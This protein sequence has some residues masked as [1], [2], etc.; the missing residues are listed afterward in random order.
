MASKVAIGKRMEV[1]TKRLQNAM[2]GVAEKLRVEA[3]NLPTHS[4]DAAL[5]PV[6]RLEVL[7][8]WAEAVAEAA[9]EKVRVAPKKQSKPRIKKVDDEGEG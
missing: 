7:A 2:Q 1:A 3:V 9:P 4:R 6:L 8:E 5:L